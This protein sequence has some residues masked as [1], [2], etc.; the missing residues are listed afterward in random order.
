MSNGNHQNL[1]GTDFKD[2]QIRK[3]LQDAPTYFAILTP[4]IQ[5][6]KLPWSLLND[7]QSAFDHGDEIFTKPVSFFFVPKG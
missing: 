3:S 6:R 4:D 7:F 5:L 2:D 1:I